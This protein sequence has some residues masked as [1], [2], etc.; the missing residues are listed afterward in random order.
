MVLV[1][2]DDSDNDGDEL[3]VA[4]NSGHWPSIDTS[5]SRYLCSTAVIGVNEAD[6]NN[7]NDDGLPPTLLQRSSNC[8]RRSNN[9][10][11]EEYPTN[12]PTNQP[13]I[14]DSSVKVGSN[15]YNGFPSTTA[16]VIP[17][18]PPVLRSR[19]FCSTVEML[20]GEKQTTIMVMNWYNSNSWPRRNKQ[21]QQQQRWLW[22]TTARNS[23]RCLD[24]TSTSRHFY[25][26]VVA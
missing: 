24:T 1:Q 10:N 20:N 23:N 26:V 3:F 15:A 16:I 4:I 18:L 5:V 17:V 19:Y 22:R 7:K 21:Y 6:N 8:W 12:Q 11:N 13:T 25:T 2:N 9:H 14:V